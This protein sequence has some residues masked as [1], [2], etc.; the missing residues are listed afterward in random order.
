MAVITS[1]TAV[2]CFSSAAYAESEKTD[3][4]LEYAESAAALYLN[5]YDVDDNSI[6]LS[7]SY[8]VYNLDEEENSNDLY[9]VF[10]DDTIIGMLSV[11]EINGEF[12]SSFEFNRLF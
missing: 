6:Y 11:T 4:K 10:E 5:S 9:I 7:Q 2:N 8:N 3:S 1:C 12:Y